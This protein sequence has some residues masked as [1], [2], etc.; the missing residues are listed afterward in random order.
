MY[1][2]KTYPLSCFGEDLFWQSFELKTKHEMKDGVSCT[3]DESKKHENIGENSRQ[4]VKI[5]PYS[6]NTSIISLSQRAHITESKTRKN[7]RIPDVPQ[8]IQ[9]YSLPLSAKKVIIFDFGLDLGGDFAP[10][11][12]DCYYICLF[13]SS[14][15]RV[16]EETIDY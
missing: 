1:K 11:R 8:I 4:Q 12:E 2:Y 10:T 15:T 16:V 13:P 7:R 5:F 9:A 14:S 6:N 3:Q